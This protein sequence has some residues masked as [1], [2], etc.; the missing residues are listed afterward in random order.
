MLS[1]QI[2]SYAQNSSRNGVS[3]KQGRYNEGWEHNS[4][5]P[6]SSKVTLEKSTYFKMNNKIRD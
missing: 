4:Y 3:E 5:K 6:K 2:F 1:M